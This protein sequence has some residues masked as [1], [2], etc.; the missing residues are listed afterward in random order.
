MKHLARET[1]AGLGPVNLVAQDGMAEMMQVHADLVRSPAVQ[2]AFDQA[3]LGARAQD[4]IIGLG[5][6]AAL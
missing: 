4:A 6:T 3:D 2:L 1:L 5:L